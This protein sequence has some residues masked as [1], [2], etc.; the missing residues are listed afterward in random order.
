MLMETPGVYAADPAV[1]QQ[2]RRALYERGVDREVQLA[3]AAYHAGRG[4][5]RAIQQ[6]KTQMKLT[7]ADGTTHL[8]DVQ[9]A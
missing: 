7:G 9:R 3:Q 5:A 6:L 2:E 4:K 8:L 1:A